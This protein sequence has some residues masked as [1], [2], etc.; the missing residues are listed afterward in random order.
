MSVPDAVALRAARHPEA[1]AVSGVGEQ[2]TYRQLCDLA[3]EVAG[4][5]TGLGTGAEGGVG[6]LVGRSAAQ[7]TVSVAALRAGAAYV[8]LD[9][10]WPTARLSRVAEVAAL[11]VVIV[12][13]T[14]RSH[15]WVRQ[16]GCDVAVLT[17]DAAGRVRHGGPAGPGPSPLSRAAPGSRT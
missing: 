7:V 1:V 13:E 3:D 14:T 10:R 17:V 2:L 9:P 8:P 4:A 5:L 15:P 6:V 16:L 12:D 11:C